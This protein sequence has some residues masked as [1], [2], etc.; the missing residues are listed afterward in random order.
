MYKDVTA[1]PSPVF[2]DL[3]SCLCGLLFH[4]LFKIFK[5]LFGCLELHWGPR[6]LRCVTCDL[7]LWHADSTCGTWAPE[8]SGSVV[9]AGGLQ[10]LHGMWN[11]SF[12]SR[13]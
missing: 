1:L 13:D 6:D 10:L 12:L 9:K 5:N 11:H 3:L 8:L 7:S 2:P 4:C